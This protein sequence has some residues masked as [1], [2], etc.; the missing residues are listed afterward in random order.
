MYA[1]VRTGRAH[2]AVQIVLWDA[3]ARSVP[4]RSHIHISCRLE[5]MHIIW[6]NIDIVLDNKIINFV[7]PQRGLTGICCVVQANYDISVAHLDG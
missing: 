4:S 3:R 1:S 2:S 7:E 6:L 5:N